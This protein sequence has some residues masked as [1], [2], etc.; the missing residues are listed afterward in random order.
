LEEL[1]PN[2][3]R[4][5][6]TSEVGSGECKVVDVSGK[7]VALCNANGQFYALGN[8]CLH[9]GGPLGEGFVDC[10]NLTVHCP[11]HGWIYNLTDGALSFSPNARVE[12]FEVKVEGDAVLVAID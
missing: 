2:F 1:M 5:A 10:A 6:G 3:V 11:W 9:H 8:T 4:A 7:E 12:K